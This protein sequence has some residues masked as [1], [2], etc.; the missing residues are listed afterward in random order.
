MIGLNCKL[1]NIPAMLG[2]FIADEVFTVLSNSSREHGFASPWA[3]D[4]VIYDQV[5]T[6]FVSLIF[7]SSSSLSNYALY[8][9]TIST[10]RRGK[11]Q[12]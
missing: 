8:N 2:A 4:E 1:Q 6:V 11:K 12:A 7:H 5:D 10:K 3:P 9:S